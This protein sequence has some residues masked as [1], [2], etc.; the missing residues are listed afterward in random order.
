MTDGDL[1]I[2]LTAVLAVLTFGAWAETVIS[3]HGPYADEYRGRERR[4]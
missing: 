1:L 2:L 3:R 4:R